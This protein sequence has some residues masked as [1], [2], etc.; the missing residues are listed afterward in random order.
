MNCA[1]NRAATAVKTAHHLHFHPRYVCDVLRRLRS[2]RAGSGAGDLRS[3][4]P[5]KTPRSSLS[6]FARHRESL[7]LYHRPTLD[8]SVREGESAVADMIASNGCSPR[9][10]IGTRAK[11]NRA[12]D[13]VPSQ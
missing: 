11:L 8:T 2:A 7:A 9:P 12:R 4:L 10:V 3:A 13:E 5:T 6:P 1:I